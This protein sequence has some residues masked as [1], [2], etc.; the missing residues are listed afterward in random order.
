MKKQCYRTCRELRQR[1]H[2]WTPPKNNK[3]SR[4]AWDGLIKIWRKKLH[5]WDPANKTDKT[6]DNDDEDD[7]DSSSTDT[8]E[9]EVATD[10]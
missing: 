2:P 8:E 6:E 10:K 1:K 5:C 4:R 7:D 3:Y 9:L